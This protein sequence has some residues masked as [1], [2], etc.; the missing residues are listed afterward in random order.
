MLFVCQR[1]AKAEDQAYAC[2]G[3]VHLNG[4]EL[5]CACLCHVSGTS[6]EERDKC[7]G[8]ASEPKSEST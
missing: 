2:T 3:S 5:S 4:V 6:V 1:K 8:C 7:P